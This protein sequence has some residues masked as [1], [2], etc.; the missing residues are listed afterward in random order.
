MLLNPI[1]S[2]KLNTKYELDT[3]ENKWVIDIFT[4]IAMVTELP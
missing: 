4:L 3:T 2:G 1:V